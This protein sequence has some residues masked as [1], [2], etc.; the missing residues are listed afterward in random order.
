MKRAINPDFNEYDGTFWM[1]FEDFLKY[2]VE[3]TLCLVRNYHEARVK[4][5]FIKHSIGDNVQILSKWAYTLTVETHT[6]LFIGI[7]QEDERNLGA[8]DLRPNLDLGIVVLKIGED[9]SW[10]IHKVREGELARQCEMELELDPGTY[11]I[12]PRTSGCAMNR[13]PTRS[14]EKVDLVDNDF[15]PP[16]PSPLFIST[17]KDLFRKYDKFVD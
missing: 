7:H 8:K 6:R 9:E 10:S 2:F 1:S 15:N 3:V 4:G 12:V 17:I 14:D 13:P 16:I 11:V 5:S